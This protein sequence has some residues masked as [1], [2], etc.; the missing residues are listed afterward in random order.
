MLFYGIADAYCAANNLDLS[1]EPNAGHGPVDFKIS[2]GYNARVTVEVKYNSNPALVR[3]FEKQLP[4]YNKAEKTTYSIYLIL[5]T[6]K[7]STSIKAVEMSATLGKRQGHRVP[8]VIV[9]D[10]RRKPSASKKK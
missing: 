5:Q 8:H 7:S 2:K 1:R 3:G 6:T 4:D 10:A 9:V